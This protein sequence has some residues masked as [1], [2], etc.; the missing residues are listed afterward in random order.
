MVS[1]LYS[2]VQIELNNSS[3]YYRGLGWSIL[4]GS[5]CS[6]IR[7]FE[8]SGL[9]G[10]ESLCALSHSQV[11]NSNT[12]WLVI[13]HP[14]VRLAIEYESSSMLRLAGVKVHVDSVSTRQAPKGHLLL[15]IYFSSLS[16]AFTYLHTIYKHTSKHR[17]CIATP[18]RT[19]PSNHIFS[20]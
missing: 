2:G 19:V 6:T 17:R 10:F 13:T 7:P 8:P 5:I 15:L 4:G 14:Y 20:G 1:N 9:L 11:F 12:L 16:M 18:P 3:H